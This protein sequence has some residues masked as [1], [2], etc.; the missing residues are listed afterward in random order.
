VIASAPTPAAPRSCLYVGWV[1]HRRFGPAANA[2][3]YRMVQPMIDLAE[4]DSVFR[5]RWLWSTR[6]PNWAWFRRGDHVGDPARPLDE[7]VRELVAERIGRRPEGGIRLL[8]HPRYAGYVMNPVSFYY[9]DDAAGELDAIVAEIHNT[10]WGERHCYVLDVAAA[11]AT[12]AGRGAARFEFDKTFHVSP[13]QPMEQR[14][15]WRFSAPGERLLVHMEN[16]SRRAE[17]GADPETAR[18]FDATL[19]MR[20]Q[21]ITGGSLARTLALHPF[22]TAAVVARIYWQALRLTVKGATFHSHPRHVAKV[23]S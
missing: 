5:G 18:P 22:M 4:L 8:T 21:P 9:C 15:V 7:C 17:A 3:R 6:R 13:F 10:P 2:F 23:A 20:R 14:Y 12:S 11:R 16:H 19:V 1:R